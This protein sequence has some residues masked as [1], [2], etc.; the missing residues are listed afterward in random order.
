MPTSKSLYNQLLCSISSTDVAYRGMFQIL[1]VATCNSSLRFTSD[2]RFA[3]ETARCFFVRFYD[4]FYKCLKDFVVL[5]ERCC[6]HAAGTQSGRCKCLLSVV[7]FVIQCRQKKINITRFTEFAFCV[8]L[9]LSILSS[10]RTT[11][12][13]ILPILDMLWTCE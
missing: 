9:I 5:V 11:N 4:T 6:S 2:V 12:L 8:L 7:A 10:V 1:Y 13:R 3:S